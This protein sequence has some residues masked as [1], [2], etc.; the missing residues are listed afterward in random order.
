[1]VGMNVVAIAKLRHESQSKGNVSMSTVST[2]SP[3]SSSRALK[4]ILIGGLIAGGLDLIAAFVSFG[5][6]V[7]RVIAAGLLGRG[8]IQ[9]G[10]GTYILGVF[11]Q[12]FIATCA[13]AVYYAASRRLVFLKQHPLVCGPFFGIAVYLVMYLIVLP[14]CALH[15][16]GP[17]Q[18]AGLI[19]GLLIHMVL[20]G[21]PIA[22]SVRLF[23]E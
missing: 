17:Y 23:S 9:G 7:P 19:Q 20:I 16:H 2:L 15:A 18:L 11:L 21:L 1:M 6:G 5:P 3:A 8:A 13:A 12:F 22:L 10:A 4:P 14:L